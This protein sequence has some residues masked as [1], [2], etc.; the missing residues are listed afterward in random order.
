MTRLLWKGAAVSPTGCGRRQD[1]FQAWRGSLVAALLVLAMGFAVPVPALTLKIATIS[2]DGTVWMKELRKA[3][4][5]IK[6]RTDGRVKL[7]FYPGG[8]MGSDKNV[9]RKIRIGQLHGGAMTGGG[10]E[11][12]HF[13]S[14]IYSL[15]FAFRS[16]AEVDYVRKHMDDMILDGLWER[17]YV[18]FGLAEG[19]FAYL[20]SNTPIQRQADLGRHKIWVPEGDT[21]SQIAFKTVGVSPIPLPLPDVL[22]A[23]QTGLVDTVAASPIGA[24]ALQWHT[25]VKYVTDTP[26]MYLYGVLIIKRKVFE[27]LRPE[28]QAV[29]REVLEAAFRRLNHINREENAQARQALMEQGIRFVAPAAEEQARWYD[30][31]TRAVVAEDLFSPAV[32]QTFQKH[33]HDFRARH[34]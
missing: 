18:G 32:L 24:I 7:R 25:R 5:Q 31:V 9:L 28:D 23:L 1:A 3:A 27:R 13:D 34:P 21:M 22:T 8:V 10:L 15:P 4:A 30:L 16:F 6:A 20:M 11:Q 26:L 29:L 17:G 14:Q 19:G 2:P 12:I 33:L